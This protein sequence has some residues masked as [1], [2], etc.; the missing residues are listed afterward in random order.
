MYQSQLTHGAWDEDPTVGG[1]VRYTSSTS[2]ASVLVNGPTQ[3]QP[4][5]TV[6]RFGPEFKQYYTK[7][8]DFHLDGDV[9]IGDLVFA[10]AWWSQDDR[11]VNEY[12]EYMQ[13][14][15]TTPGL[16]NATTNP[17]P[18]NA[19][20]QQGYVCQHDPNSS[21]TYTGTA[22]PFSGCKAPV[23]YYD[24]INNTH[25]WSNELRLASKEG[26]RLHWLVGAYWEDTKNPYSNYYHMPGLQ[27]H[28]D[29]Y[30]DIVGYYGTTTKPPAPDDWY[31]YIARSDYLEITE[32]TNEV[33]DLLPNLHLELGTVHF[34]SHFSDSSYGGFWYAPQLYVYAPGSS[35]KWNSKA[36]LSWNI[37]KD[38]LLYVDAAQGFRDG[39]VNPGLP[40]NCI[41][42]G[43]AL[44][45]TPDTLTNYELG[46][47]TTWLAG[48][49]QWNGAFF[50]M[51]WH[52]LQ[53]LVFD[54][55]I[56]SSSSFTANVGNA[57]IYGSEMELT[58]QASSA[59]NF[60]L[61]SAYTSSVLLTSTYP[62][63][64]VSPGER[65]PYVPYLN[66]TAN[67]RYE[68]PLKDSLHWYGQYDA[69]HKGDMWNDLQAA[70]ENSLPRVLQPG[71]TVMNVR[72]GLTETE[73]HWMTE[74]YVT[75]LTNKNAVIYTNEGNFDLRYTRN[76]PRV[77]GLRVSYR[78]GK[79]T[80]AAED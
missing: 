62:A 3:P 55:A 45:F 21:L 52:D 68:K 48:R 61:K 27:T 79:P 38:A 39:G 32:F 70:G 47:K 7:T 67:S 53:T 22:V 50:L 8:L 24:Y 2:N 13:Y 37:T 73:R 35:N 31:S 20:T 77:F 46:W 43:A 6:A 29:A 44:E 23:Q 26:G 12:S 42:N 10:S 54:P 75:N 41:K 28:G 64:Q 33:I 59:W 36:G 16:Y 80:S 15:N 34:H 69:E 1:A 49:L 78:W 11:W 18:F 17:F 66:W 74:L 40:S 65:L 14:L 25:R 9:G 51:P 57:R 60:N 56:C 30:Q 63:F 71:Y 58:Y 76:E 4:P 19:T 5:D 72:L